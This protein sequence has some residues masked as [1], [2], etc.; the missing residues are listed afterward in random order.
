V[1]GYGIE[2]WRRGDEVEEGKDVA[3]RWRGSRDVV[4]VERVEGGGGGGVCERGAEGGG[5]RE[6]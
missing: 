4:G 6:R 1:G 3:G 2:G 5:A